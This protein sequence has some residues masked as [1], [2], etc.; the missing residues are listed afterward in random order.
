MRAVKGWG[1]TEAKACDITFGCAKAN[2]HLFLL[3]KLIIGKNHTEPER[4]EKHAPNEVLIF[5]KP[6]RFYRNLIFFRKTEV[7]T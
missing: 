6:G 3:P 5:Q 4:T 2:M 7:F 1:K